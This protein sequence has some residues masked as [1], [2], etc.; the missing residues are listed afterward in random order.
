[1]YPW[2]PVAAGEAAPQ[3][4]GTAFV[5]A[6]KKARVLC[7]HAAQSGWC[8]ELTLMHEADAGQDH[9]M[10]RASRRAA[11][12]ALAP[13]LARPGAVILDVG[14]SSGFF[15]RELQRRA[16]GAFAIGA[17][18]LVEP[19]ERLGRTLPGVPL[20]QF[21]LTRAPLPDR[22]LD[23]FVALNVLEHIEDHALAMAHLARMLKPG[24]IGVIE[25][26][27]GQ[28]LYDFY[29]AHLLHFRR[30]ALTDLCTM[31]RAAGLEVLKAS[32]LGCFLYPAFSFMKKRN[33]RLSRTLAAAEQKNLVQRQIRL[34]KSN[35][36]FHA[37][38]FLERALGRFL[39]F[40]WGI[41]CWLKVRR[42]LQEASPA[43]GGPEQARQHSA[44]RDHAPA[45]ATLINFPPPPA[46]ALPWVDGPR[47]LVAPRS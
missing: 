45:A 44:R 15:L 18:F 35:P 6:G 17:D 16:P 12:A 24:G 4:N 5:A 33:Q 41:R 46:A 40:P 26:P 37:C 47:P 9:Y 39:N 19:L 2:P 34:A 14:C 10:D 1:M 27:A 11:L 38:M 21:D 28:H 42:P 22:Q 20:L 36:V 8:D 3:W 13:V 29:D 32:H 23:G 7:Y 31:A 43:T 30:Y 25:V